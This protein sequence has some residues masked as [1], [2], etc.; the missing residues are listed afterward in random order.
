M[1]QNLAH[2][3]L[4]FRWSGEGPA[5]SARLPDKAFPNRSCVG[6]T[7]LRNAVQLHASMSQSGCNVHHDN[8]IDSTVFYEP[9]T[10]SGSNEARIG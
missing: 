2:L 1:R 6:W 5:S 10:R 4:C 9:A 3:F 7:P 8:D